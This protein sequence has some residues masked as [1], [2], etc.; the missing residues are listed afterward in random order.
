MKLLKFNLPFIINHKLMKRQL[1]SLLF[2]LCI[3]N[4]FAQMVDKV[5]FE[6]GVDYINCQ[7]TKISLT[8]QEGQAHLADF[9]QEIGNHNRNFEDLVVFLKTRP[10]GVMTKNLELAFFINSYKD[11]YDNKSTNEELYTTLRTDLLK[12]VPIQNFKIKHQSS[13]SGFEENVDEYLIN[14]LKLQNTVTETIEDE[15]LDDIVMVEEG[16]E[17]P[18]TNN[19]TK[20]TTTE[21]NPPIIID[22]EP[23]QPEIMP[24]EF[25]EEDSIFSWSSWLFRFSLLFASL[26]VLLYVLLP[27]YEKRE[28]AKVKKPG[29]EV[30]PQAL[31][32]EAEVAI[33]ENKNR[34][35]RQKIDKMH[36]D[37]N[38]YEDTFRSL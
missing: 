33:L 31:S 1:L 12:E 6:R 11:K 20:E 37:L 30:H 16:E 27:Y 17:E 22:E 9:N 14:L 23:E 29:N 38:E 26:A 3:T 8:D 5:V 2:L 4:V 36:L 34:I 7:L 28:K 32:L 25:E 24:F 19:N 18:T 15:Y 13:F 35:L 10:T 21:E